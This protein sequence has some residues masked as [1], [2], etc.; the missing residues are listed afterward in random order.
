MYSG[1]G[2]YNTNTYAPSFWYGSHVYGP[3]FMVG[4]MRF[5]MG[6]TGQEEKPTDLMVLAM[7]TWMV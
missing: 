5:R 1:S 7:K 3:G 2:M 6:S 4:V